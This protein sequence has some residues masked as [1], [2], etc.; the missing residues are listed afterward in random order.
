MKD[1]HLYLLHISESLERI[2]EYIAEGGEAFLAD[3]KTQDAVLRNLQTLA[4]ST[5]RLS[6]PLKAL[7]RNASERRSEV[8][9]FTDR[10]D[11]LRRRGFEIK[12]REFMPV[13]LSALALAET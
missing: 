10:L 5:Q 9:A 6:D 1:D 13:G 2:E 11:T 4:E 8:G 12:A 3:R 7:A